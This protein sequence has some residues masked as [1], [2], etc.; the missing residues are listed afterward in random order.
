MIKMIVM[1]LDG[2]LLDDCLNISAYTLSILGECRNRGIRI[3]I[4]TA[5]SR[6]TAETI[7]DLVQP[8]FSILNDGAIIMDSCDNVIHNELHLLDEVAEIDYD[9]IENLNLNKM[10]AITILAKSQDIAVSEVLAFGDGAND[11]KMILYC[12]TGVAMENASHD[13]KSYANDVCKSNNENGV[14]IWI[15]EHILGAAPSVIH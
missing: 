6:Q 8:D 5:R 14:A 11:I 9:Y 15:E 12:G 3:V 1:D 10:N 7:I 13:V 4:A 2:T